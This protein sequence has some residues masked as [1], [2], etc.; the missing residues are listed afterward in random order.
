MSR[1]VSNLGLQNLGGEVPTLGEQVTYVNGG[2]Y[3]KRFSL[4][5]AG[6]LAFVTTVY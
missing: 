5:P 2:Y 6:I 4:Q 1:T 3:R